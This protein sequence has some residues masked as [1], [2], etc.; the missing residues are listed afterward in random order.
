MGVLD[1]G[2]DAHGE[3]NLLPGLSNVD[4]VNTI[5]PALPDVR[6]YV[7]VAVLCANVTLCRQKELDFIVVR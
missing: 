4:D 6:L 2:D 1:G 3:D 5:G 7:V